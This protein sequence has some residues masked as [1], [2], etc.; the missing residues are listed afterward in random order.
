MK[1]YIALL[2]MVAVLALALTGIAA[3]QPAGTG[4]IEGQVTNGTA[5]GGSVADQKVTLETYLN[6][7][8]EGQPQTTQT[9]A[10]GK[11]QFTGLST[12]AGYAYFAVVRYQTADYTSDPVTFKEGETSKSVEVQVYETTES[13]A[14]IIISNQHTIIEP[15]NGQL[16]VTEVIRF[17]NG[18]DRTY[19]GAPATGTAG[20][21]ETLRFQLPPDASGFQ[22]GQGLVSSFLT[23]LAAGFSD[24]MPLSPGPNDIS[25]SYVIAPGTDSYTFSQQPS[26]YQV[27]SFNFVVR[28]DGI[29]VKADQM[30]RG[31][32]MN[33]QGQQFVPFSASNVAPGTVLQLQFSG[34]T[35][36]AGAG[37]DGGS[38]AW[39]V[40]VVLGCL[41]VCALVY[42]FVQKRKSGTAPVPVTGTSVDREQERSKLLLEIARLDDEFEAGNLKEDVYRQKRAKIKAR[43]I[44]GSSS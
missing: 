16:A 31:Q 24:S 37:D 27:A 32:A 7:A 35:K 5:G 4:V 21:R 29:E 17:L 14:A 23:P 41:L 19:I 3:A 25:Y 13:D 39:I 20:G 11:F 26:K 15:G 18:G 34:L 1:K 30:T 10:Q 40:I 8:P 42:I 9:D 6:N 22:P 38:A 33:I 2:L 28:V 43:L 12:G 36:S 44:E